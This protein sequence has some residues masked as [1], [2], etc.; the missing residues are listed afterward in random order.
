MTIASFRLAS[1]GWAVATLLAALAPDS[2]SAQRYDRRMVI[3]ND[4][5]RTL[6]ELYA[7]NSG[8]KNWGRDHL[9]QSV[10]PHGG[11]YVID[12]NDGTGSCVFDFRAVLDNGIPIER[13]RVDVCTDSSWVVR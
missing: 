13:Y 9:G 3:I 1:F 7:T 11:R 4:T 2:A 12:F 8:T 6:Q 5:G 10:I